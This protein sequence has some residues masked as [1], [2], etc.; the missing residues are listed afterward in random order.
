MWIFTNESE[1]GTGV[2]PYREHD[3]ALPRGVR[4]NMC[5]AKTADVHHIEGVRT[6]CTL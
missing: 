2:L 3:S 6:V 4:I 1:M 5:Q